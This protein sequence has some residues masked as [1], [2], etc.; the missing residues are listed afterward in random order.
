MG[1]L[2]KYRKQKYRRKIPR[3]IQIKVVR[4]LQKK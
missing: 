2:N 1:P 4:E 3:K